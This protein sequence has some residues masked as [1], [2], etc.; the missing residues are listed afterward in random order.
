MVEI[1]LY[2]QVKSKGV[3]IPFFACTYL[4]VKPRGGTIACKPAPCG[5]AILWLIREATG[6]TMEKTGQ[7]FTA[8]GLP[9]LIAD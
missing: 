4:D 8:S 2:E 5:V 6:K 7:A 3:N 9:G 1:Q